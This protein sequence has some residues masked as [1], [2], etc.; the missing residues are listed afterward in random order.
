MQQEL[1]K[2]KRMF[3]GGA[4]PATIGTGVEEVG[5]Q[6]H[7]DMQMAARLQ[8]EEFDSHRTA[9]AAHAPAKK[10]PRIN[11]LDAFVRRRL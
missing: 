11:T 3:D 1:R 6:E 4:A 9:F 2:L 7:M 8:R 5:Q 10:V